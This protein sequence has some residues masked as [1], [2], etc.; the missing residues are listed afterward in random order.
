MKI[1][2]VNIFADV[3]QASESVTLIDIQINTVMVYHF[4]GLEEKISSIPS[5]YPHSSRRTILMM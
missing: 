1:K 5:E 3:L 2:N 4:T